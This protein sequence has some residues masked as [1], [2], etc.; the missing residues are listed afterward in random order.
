M[1]ITIV[2]CVKISFIEKLINL[3]LN[4]LI[5]NAARYSAALSLFYKNVFIYHKLL[6]IFILLL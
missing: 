4:K 2:K 6:K 1:E 3:F 5:E